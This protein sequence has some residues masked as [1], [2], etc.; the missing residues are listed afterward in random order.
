MKTRNHLLA[1]LVLIS[2]PAPLLA[3][4]CDV[5]PPFC[6]ALPNTG[7]ANHAVF[8]GRVTQVY[9]SRA[10]MDRLREEFGR[11]HRDLLEAL[12]TQSPNTTGRVV[13]GVGASSA[14]VELKKQFIEYVWGDTLTPA[15]REELRTANQREM[16]RL[17][18]EF[19]QRVHLEVVE[20]FTGADAGEFTLYTESQSCGFDF[21]EGETYLV[22]THKKVATGTWEASSCSRTRLLAQATEDFEALHAWKTGQRLPG[23]ISGQ[24]IELVTVLGPGPARRL[25]PSGTPFRIRLLGGKEILETTSD[26]RGKFKFENLDPGFYEVELVQAPAV[27]GAADMTN[28]SCATVDLSIRR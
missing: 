3:C 23:R 21:A 20:N 4:F 26:S 1:G 10:D 28:A 7:D 12:R 17:A 2:L 27:R 22:D 18:F 5:P 19:R 9:P 25:P 16:D 8:V 15:E 13:A 6:G 11:T 14:E 24:I